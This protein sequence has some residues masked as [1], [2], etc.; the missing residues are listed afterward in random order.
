MSDTK[1]IEQNRE[2]RGI[3]EKMKKLS[4]QRIMIIVVS[5]LLV[6]GVIVWVNVYIQK[7]NN[8]REE[9]AQ[10]E[11]QE[12]LLA[13]Q[14]E[15]KKQEELKA[16]EEA[17]KQAEEKEAQEEVTNVAT[18]PMTEAEAWQLILDNVE[19][20]Q[21]YPWKL[22]GQG[23]ETGKEWWSW[24]GKGE[25]NGKLAYG[26]L[27]MTANVIDANTISVKCYKMFEEGSAKEIAT[28]TLTRTGNF[29]QEEM[30][31]NA[32]AP[33][34]QEE[35][36]QLILDN[37]KPNQS[38]TWTLDYVDD[39]RGNANWIWVA[40]DSNNNTVEEIS[41][42]VLDAET[43]YVEHMGIEGTMGTTLGECTLKRTG[44]FTPEQS[45]QN[46]S[47]ERQGEE[48]NSMAIQEHYSGIYS[49]GKDWSDSGKSFVSKLQVEDDRMLVWGMASNGQSNIEL[50]GEAYKYDENF[51]Y[52]GMSKN[53]SI[54]ILKGQFNEGQSMYESMIRFE[55]QDDTMLSFSVGAS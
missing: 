10:L 52:R 48:G 41:A 29:A 35:A 19:F 18:T 23:G 8:K 25:L 42:T 39:G 24:M 22:E 31:N 1:L 6:M 33:I 21:T 54:E 51:S 46:S 55:V 30:P 50:N 26:V 40:T 49:S 43:I 34:T 16:Q 12:R 47:D 15:A 17:K 3:I 28:Y 37:V 27:S 4:V 20:D 13:E 44:N 5:I 2:T 11:E 7:E 14:E 53:Q 9:Q 36:W 45:A 38:Y 32:N